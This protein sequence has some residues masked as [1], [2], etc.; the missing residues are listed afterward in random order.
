MTGLLTID[1]AAR[2]LGVS[3]SSLRRWTRLGTLPCARVGARRERR[4]RREDLDRLLA[5]DPSAAP[6]AAPA[7]GPS[8]PLQALA[9]AAQRGVPRHVCLHFRDRDE[10][11]QMFRPYVLDHA[12]RCPILYVHEENSR[13]DV[14]GRLRGEGLDPK[15]LAADGLLRLLVPSEAYLR[16]GSFE[17]QRMIDFMEGAIL[18]RRAAGFDAMLV[19]GEMTWYL[20]GAPG[21]EG[22]VEYETLLNDMLLRYPQVTIVCH[23]DMHR[24]DGAITLGALCSH[25]HVHLPHGM[26]PGYFAHSASGTNLGVA[27]G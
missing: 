18:E 10:L 26:L 16:T 20:S 14:L 8:D 22:M 13:A 11:W 23:Y 27:P 6:A 19:S 15:R 7:D 3:K 17:P 4:F 5:A 21:V 12:E 1:D 24:L 9:A 25:P 2:Y